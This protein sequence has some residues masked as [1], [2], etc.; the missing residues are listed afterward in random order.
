MSKAQQ[1]QIKYFKETGQIAKA[2]GIIYD[3]VTQK[4]GGL[5]EQ[6]AKTPEGKLKMAA[7]SLT[8]LKIAAGGAFMM[9]AV[10]VIPIF[11]KLIQNLKDFGKWISGTSKGAVILKDAILG[12]TGALVIYNAVMA[13]AAI[14]TA[15]IVWWNG[16]ST[17]AIIL[18]T[19]ATEGLSA[20]WTALGIAFAMNPIGFIITLI[21]ALSVAIMALWD[22]FE[23]FR[24]GTMAL[25]EV[26][27]KYVG[28]IIDVYMNLAKAVFHVFEM[29]FDPKRFKQHWKELQTDAKTFVKDVK[30]DFISGWGDAWKKGL[31][32]GKNSTFKFASLLG[33]NGKKG[34]PNAIAE[35]AGMKNDFTGNSS[36]GSLT[37]NGFATSDL[38]GAKGGLGEAKIINIRMDDGLKIVVPNGDSKDI[39]ANADRTMDVVLRAINNVTHSQSGIM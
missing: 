39:L 36:G 1:D 25:W 11:L 35:M 7:K 10:K 34:S 9:L 20:A 26:V 33:L 37:E 19:L 30:E 15:L 22:N 5:S 8:D 21:V 28:G 27:K 6:L 23:G 2:Q 13:I 32:E 3:F 12:I 31:G 4:V 38:A 16:M 14:R 18:N 17:T 24:S 29:I